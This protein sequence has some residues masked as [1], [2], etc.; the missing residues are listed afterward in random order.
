[1]L[2]QSLSFLL[3]E[4]VDC[5]KESTYTVG[6]RIEFCLMIGLNGLFSVSKLY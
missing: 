1:M 5:C 6:V 3:D 2:S 4:L